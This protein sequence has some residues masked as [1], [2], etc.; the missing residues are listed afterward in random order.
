M[1]TTLHTCSVGTTIH[2]LPKSNFL[3]IHIME[4]KQIEYSCFC[5][6][7]DL[8]SPSLSKVDLLQ[9]CWE[10]WQNLNA[11]NEFT[12]I[13]RSN[14]MQLMKNQKI[15]TKGRKLHE[16]VREFAYMGRIV[17]ISCL[18]F[19]EPPVPA[20]F[21]KIFRACQEDILLPAPV[22]YHQAISN[23]LMYAASSQNQ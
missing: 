16:S 14:P 15:H 7:A 19:D 9:H 22:L 17:S 23:F 21:T 8:S 4:L 2:H 6:H 5:P 1:A 10:A 11:V 12:P 20:R 13:P 3:Y 18:D